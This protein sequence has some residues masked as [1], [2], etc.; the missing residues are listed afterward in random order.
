MFFALNFRFRQRDTTASLSNLER[1]RS[2]MQLLVGSPVLSPVDNFDIS[3]ARPG[4]S[5]NPYSRPHCS[6]TASA[7]EAHINLTISFE[8]SDDNCGAG[9]PCIFTSKFDKVLVLPSQSSSYNFG[10]ICNK[11]P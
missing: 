1:S 11:S 4:R 8:T 10:G 6:F 3:V 2:L 5:E 7:A 9:I